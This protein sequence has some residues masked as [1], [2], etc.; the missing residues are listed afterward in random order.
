MVTGGNIDAFSSDK[1]VGVWDCFNLRDVSI[2]V[3]LFYE[4]NLVGIS[5]FE[6]ICIFFKY[7]SFRF[8]FFSLFDYLCI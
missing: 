6:N 7:L 3:L 4:Q 2:T 5:Q 8:R 1:Y